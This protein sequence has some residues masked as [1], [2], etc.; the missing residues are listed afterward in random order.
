MRL[1]A[2]VLVMAAMFGAACRPNLAPV[3]T[4]PRV[5][6]SPSVTAVDVCWVESR[7]KFGFTA[8]S[9]VVRHPSGATLLIDA[10]NSTHVREEIDVYEGAT[11]RWMATFP[12]SLAPKQPLDERLRAEGVDPGTLRAVIPTHAHLDHLGGVLDLPPVPV[13]VSAEEAAVIEHGRTHVTFEVTPAHA[14]AV[15]E[16]LETIAFKEEPYEIFPRHADLFGDGSVVV[17]PLSGHTPGSVGVFLQR[18][19]G[20]RI[21][22]LGD[23]VNM[24]RQLTSL[25][26][27]TPAMRRTD[28][29]RSRAEAVVGELHGLREQEPSIVYLPAHERRAWVAAFGEPGCG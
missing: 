5:S 19:D 8:S 4:P 18:A 10:G 21:F 27:K 2:L 22:H 16:R 3:P 23:A 12:A 28:H 29:D 13:W 14:D 7:A 9:L 17:V 24:R 11:K 26:G 1:R 20:Q 6:P 15:A 25:Q